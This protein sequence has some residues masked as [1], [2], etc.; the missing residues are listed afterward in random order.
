ME[1][2]GGSCFTPYTTYVAPNYKTIFFGKRGN[3]T[4]RY[5]LD[6][7]PLS[8]IWT[9][10]CMQLSAHTLGCEMGCWGQVMRV[11]KYAYFARNKFG[12]LSI[13]L[14]FNVVPLITFDLCFPHILNQTQFL[15]EFLLQSQCAL[16]IATFLVKFLNIESCYSLS[17]VLCEM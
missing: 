16:S 12:R 4:H 14:W 10:T 15:H 2:S 8:I 6:L 11:V 13:T 1:K 17:H 3:P 9:I 5:M 7:I